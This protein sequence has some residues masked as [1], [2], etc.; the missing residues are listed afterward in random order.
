MTD[1]IKIKGFCVSKGFI[2]KVKIQTIESG[3]NC[4]NHASDKQL[5][6]RICKE[7]LQGHNKKPNNSIC[8]QAKDLNRHF[9][10]KDI[11]MT[12]KIMK[13]CSTSLVIKEY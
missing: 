1:I 11:Q 4:D 2:K 7:V 8:K 6:S 3:K 10:K 12:N 13:R 9:S 5:I